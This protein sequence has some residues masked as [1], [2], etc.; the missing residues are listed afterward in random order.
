MPEIVFKGS[1]RVPTWVQDLESF[2]R[3]TR[4]E[5]FPEQG[6]ISYLGGLL[7]VDLSM[8][9]DAHN[10]IKS[11]VGAT[12]RVVNSGGKLGRD[13]QDGMRLTHPEVGLSTQPDGL[14]FAWE[15]LQ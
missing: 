13:Y 15:T 2:R 7:W 8:E 6:N 9:R 1:G 12:F 3:W 11:G 4:S 10:Q 5:E 14:Y